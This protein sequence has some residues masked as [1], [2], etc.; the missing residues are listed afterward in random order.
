MLFT[1][2]D[3]IE[4]PN[5][6]EAIN[7]L[8][9]LA[10]RGYFPLPEYEYEQSYDSNGNSVW[11]CICS[12]DGCDRFSKSKSS[13]KKDAKKSAAFKMLKYVLN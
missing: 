7:Q 10:R 9:T 1:I 2:R 12:I 6:D 3:E 8:E 4:N 13:S 5:K 11:V